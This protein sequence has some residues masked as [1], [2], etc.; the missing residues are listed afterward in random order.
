MSTFVQ[1]AA[2][3]GIALATVATLA[4]TAGAQ[5]LSAADVATI[6][7]QIQAL[8]S[9]LAAA[10]VST[11]SVSSYT[12][13]RNLTV[14]AKG[15][16]VKALQ[17]VLISGGYLK[18]SAPTGFFG[19]MTKAALAAWQSAKG[20]SPAAGF[21]GSISRAAMSASGPVVVV[22]PVVVPSGTDLVV[23]AASDSPS[24]MVVGSGT[25]FNPA[26][27]VKFMA[28]SKDV[29]VS[30]ISFMK[31]GFVANSNLNGV[32][33]V[34]AMGVR[35]GQVISSVNADNTILV[36]FGSTPLVVSA[37]TSKTLTVRFNLAASASAGT[38]SFS[39]PSVSSIT[40]DTS[41]IS[42]SFPINGAA[43]QIV[44]GNTALAS[45]SLDV[46]TSTGSSTL[47]VDPASEQEITK[48]R[49]V[50]RS[51]NEALKIYSWTLYNYGNAGAQDYSD[52]Q[53]VAQDGTVL[54]T[55][56]PMG[57][58]VTFNLSA[59]PYTI[60]KGLTKD[61]T[62]KAKLIGGTT[63]TIKFV[64]YNN[65]D[66]DFR[67]ATTGVSILPNAVAG[68]NDTSFPIGNAYNQTTI[69]SGT[70]TLT[71]STDSPS[72][73]VVP[74]SNSVVM[75]KYTV[76]PTGENYELRQVI[77]GMTQS[78]TA[79]T[80][81]VIV[82]VNGAV[83][84]SEGASAWATSGTTRTVTLSSYPVLVAGQDSFITIEASVNST[85]T[86]SDSYTVNAFN[87]AQAK[88]LVTNDI[89]SNG[90]TGLTTTAASGLAISVKAAK[91]AVTTL[92][93]PVANSVVA[94]TNGYEY[95]T[96]QLNSQAG[97]EDVKVTT[98][99]VTHTGSNATQVANLVIYKDADTSPLATTASTATNAATVTFN[100]SSPI[101]VSRSTPVTLHLKADAVSGASAHTF[102]IASSTSAL[103][104]TGLT[105]GNSLTNGSD[106]TF[107][108][109]GQA[110]THVPSGTM[111]IALVS[112]AG[113]SPSQNQVVSVGT[114]DGVYF[115]FKMS[116][117]FETQKITSLKLS[118]SATALAT[119]TLTNIRVFEGSTQIA[120][121]PQFDACS[122]TLCTVTFTSTDN[123]L[124]APVP[125][126]GVT[127]Y[128]KANTA[129]GG[130]AILGDD[131]IMKIAATADVAVKGSV[132][133]TTTATITGT[134]TAS[135]ITYVVP[136]NVAISAVTPTSATNV[137]LGSGQTVGVF[138][139][140]NNGSA[141]IY[142][143]T[144]TLTFTNGG[145]ASSSLTFKIYA[146]AVGGG[147]SDTSAWNSG[148]GYAANTGTFGPS[149]TIP[150]SAAAVTPVE[151]KIDGG[152]WR[153]LTIKTGAAAANNDTFQ[154]SVS[155]LGN[156][157][158]YALESDLGYSGN[159]DSDLSDT[160][161]GL[162]VDGIPALA[163][164]TAKT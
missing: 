78:T 30:A 128:V 121:A 100:F 101:T 33:V 134:P 48:F 53:L 28:G 6:M 127:L 32:D 129:A 136:Q 162:K 36:T 92:A 114:N 64:V 152:S 51:S 156:I 144:S 155:A 74:G 62:I 146:S 119:T 87:L 31:S 47:N 86:A 52:V 46:L 55:A 95:A 139:V 105:T 9:Q 66:V 111:N 35:Y 126:T 15:D 149:S 130:A 38:V 61:F 12:F 137:G 102:N 140:M 116:S 26:L 85:A 110:Q 56:Q 103:S 150:F 154:L 109:A 88:R 135:G 41:A 131:F 40:A 67:G 96:F 83:V 124:S 80:G 16:D 23:S 148:S 63:K 107:A 1:K 27:K 97:G 17:N 79:L 143:A 4:G 82:K 54:A 3:I 71:R 94:G 59:N 24:A 49:V 81:S 19:A 122:G 153:Y 43:M 68:Q 69:G 8:Q 70:I 5:S 7:A 151:A 158:F 50:E 125:T 72:T 133:A 160:I 65:Y 89:L 75:A 58:Y 117:Q 20:I 39:V 73:S 34:D 14:G 104:A 147:Q 115:A 145:T 161:T 112:G 76:K 84:Y 29:K 60:D 163:T 13:T 106:I 108:G 25:A 18:V 2:S 42:G 21:F 164:V 22:P 99:V 90:D 77:F 10:Q 118:A 132:T 45:S 141:P 37:G 57:Q 138:K 91:L 157:L 123:L 11:P 120:S 98:I 113:A 159:A 142:L 93:T 44:A